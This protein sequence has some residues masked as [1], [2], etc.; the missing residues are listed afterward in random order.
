MHLRQGYCDDYNERG[1]QSGARRVIASRGWRR[2][3][4]ISARYVV[5]LKENPF[6]FSQTWDNI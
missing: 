6:E 2:L 4:D 5:T 3:F 1:R